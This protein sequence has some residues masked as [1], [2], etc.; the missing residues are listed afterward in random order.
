[1]V[2]ALAAPHRARQPD[3][4][5]VAYPVGGVLGRVF[6]RLGAPFLGGLQHAVVTR[7][8]LL[9]ARRVR[10]QIAGQLLDGELVEALVVVK[11]VDDVIAVEPDVA[12]VVAVV[13]ARVGVANEIEPVD[14]HALAVVL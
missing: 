2:V 5:D 11:S 3:A 7:G 4:G 10:Q 13:A 6:L 1:M 8:D 9:L 14:R 12:V